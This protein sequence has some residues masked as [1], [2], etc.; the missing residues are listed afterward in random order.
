MVK[1]TFR[2][3]NNEAEYEALMVG[4][5]IEKAL[6]ATKVKVKADSQVVVNQV[7]G[8]YTTRGVNLEN[9]L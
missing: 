9:Y 4:L 2:T 6:R 3:T 8:V 5:S 1:L 7:L